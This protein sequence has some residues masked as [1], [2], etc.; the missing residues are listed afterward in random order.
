MTYNIAISF[1][2]CK[3]VLKNVK[4]VSKIVDFPDIVNPCIILFGINQYC[5]VAPLV[6]FFPWPMSFLHVCF[7]CLSEVKCHRTI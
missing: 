2:S 5:P 1:L 4:L 7:K 6:I 3:N